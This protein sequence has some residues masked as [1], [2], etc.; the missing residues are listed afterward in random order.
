MST[1]GNN[2]A[3]RGNNM[4]TRGNNMSTRGN[5]MST[6]GNNMSTRGNNMSTRGNNMSTRGNNM[7]TR[8]NTSIRGKTSIRGN[9]K[10]CENIPILPHTE[11]SYNRNLK[12]GIMNGY[13]PIVEQEKILI[14]NINETRLISEKMSE[15]TKYR[16]H[17]LR[18]DRMVN[19]LDRTRKD[20]LD[21]VLN[22]FE[23]VFMLRPKDENHPLNQIRSKVLFSR[24]G[25]ANRFSIRDEDNNSIE[26]II[27]KVDIVG[28]YIE[29]HNILDKCDL[30]Y[31]DSVLFDIDSRLITTD[32]Y[33][34]I[35][36]RIK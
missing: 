18:K 16:F 31:I 26:T 5:N 27:E 2:M 7:S 11:F 4:A 30:H 32:E 8:G 15:E 1:R 25:N 34:C 19:E 20:K 22:N 36:T 13:D 17:Q 29:R 28:S 21:Y 35:V 33:L 10:F 9:R 23:K 3:T 6:R 24:E 14:E 12:K